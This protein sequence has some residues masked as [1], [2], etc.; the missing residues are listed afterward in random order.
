MWRLVSAALATE[1]AA[2]ALTAPTA[3]P[4]VACFRCPLGIL[5][6]VLAAV[7]AAPL[8]LLLLSW[9]LLRRPD[10]VAAVGR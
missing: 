3:V 9:L 1:P 8:L 2:A 6:L 5:S 4:H 10:N 7:A